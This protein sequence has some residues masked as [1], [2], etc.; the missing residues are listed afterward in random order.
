M[1]TLILLLIVAAFL[2]TTVIPV[3]LVLIILI[4]RA[5]LK[6]EDK[7][8]YLAFG[9]GLL[10]SHLNLV[11]LGFHSLLYLTFIQLT[12]ALAKSRL[13][14]NSL[15]LIPLI[16]IFM[17]ITQLLNIY[18]LSQSLNIFPRVLIETSLSIP[19]FYAVKI[20][21]ERFIVRKDIKLR[22]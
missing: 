16:F 10:I 20:W 2:Q 17:L 12:Q 6:P 7:N 19:I 18:L 21:E 22:V 8:L 5:Y 13:A 11:V 9:F 15:A 14:G 3:N 4:C 1:K